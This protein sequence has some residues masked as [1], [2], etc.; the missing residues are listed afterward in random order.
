MF[1][2][3]DLFVTAYICYFVV[4][5]YISL[6]THTKQQGVFIFP[7]AAL[8]FPRGNPTDGLNLNQHYNSIAYAKSGEVLIACSQNS[9]YVSMY[10]PGRS[11]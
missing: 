8:P 6:K 7:V 2:L 3:L 11:S 4:V 9:P 5:F 1:L 10:E